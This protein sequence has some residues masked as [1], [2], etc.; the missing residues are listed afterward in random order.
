MDKA[1]NRSGSPTAETGSAA[2]DVREFG[3]QLVV[4]SLAAVRVRVL[5]RLI[6][7]R[8][9]G[10]VLVLVP[11]V[12][13]WEMLAGYIF[14]RPSFPRASLIA[15]KW[16]ELVANGDIPSALLP[17]FRRI[18]VGY[19]L[20]LVTAVPFGV[21]MGA[22]RVAYHLFEPLVELLRP[23]P[24]SAL[25]PLL[26]IFLGLG[27]GMNIGLIVFASF[28]PIVLNTY[29]GIRDVDPV[30]INTARTLGG[31]PS[32]IIRL[33]RLPSAMP[34]IFTGMRISLAVSLILAVIAEMLAGNSGIGFFTIQ[35][36][37]GFR[38]TTMYAGI[39]TLGLVGYI[40]NRVFLLV[41]KRFLR[42]HFGFSQ[43]QV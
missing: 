17:T 16:F 30:L 2:Q 28:F 9:L 3:Q 38:V 23:I 6:D 5:R 40:F 37:R 31:R 34:Q 1:T 12:I 14:D 29:S 36:Q 42:W 27:D 43:V 11:L 18:G 33:V 7:S 20:A 41:E 26:I 13:M 15:V 21:L 10:V 24:A 4:P 35:A 8:M 19:A 25:V 32:E 39:L 22:S